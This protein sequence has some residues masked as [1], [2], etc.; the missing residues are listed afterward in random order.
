MRGEEFDRLVDAHREHFADV[1]AA[2]RD[3]Q[4]LGI[5]ALAA[6]GVAQHLDV[7]QEAHL[8]RLHALPFAAFAAAARRVERK[9]TR[10]CSRARA[11]RSRPQ[12]PCG[13]R[14][15]SRRTWPGT[16]AA[17]C[18]SA[19]GRPRARGR[20]TP[21][22]SMPSQPT[23]GGG[24]PAAR[25]R[26]ARAQVRVQH[27]ARERRLAR[28]R[29]TG[30]DR[31][32]AERH[33]R[34]DLAQVVQRGALDLERTAPARPTGRRRAERMA[35]RVARGTARSATAATRSGRRCAGADDV[36]AARAGAGTEVDQVIGAPDRVLVVLDDEQR[37]ALARRAVRARRAARRCRADA[38]RS[39][40]RRA[41]SR[42]R[43]G[44]SRVARRGGCAAPRRRTAS[45]RRGRARYNPGRRRAGRPGASGSPRCR[46]RAI[47]ASRPCSLQTSRKTR[48][49]RRPAA[50]AS[51]AIDW[52]AKR[53]VERDRD[54]AA[55][56]RRPGRRVA[57]PSNHSFHQISSPDCSASKPLMRTPVPKHAS[58]QPCFELY[59]NSRGS[60]SAKLR[61]HDGAGATR[62]ENAHLAAVDDVR[63]ALA[64][65]ERALQRVTQLPLVLRRDLDARRRAARSCA[66]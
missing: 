55:A 16:N 6:A 17:S 22:P 13:S 61:P 54:S 42:R 59:E 39:S 36:A 23:Q 15:R 51:S 60:G 65:V 32:P 35:Q 46:S 28:T 41:R 10:R 29:H 48:A 66:P 20:A 62:R 5:E 21:Q 57:S 14:P 4:R 24:L 11:H 47:S 56:R 58:H 2:I 26:Q 8:D 40:A 45:A 38:G 64:E 7:R 3:R 44:S 18:R 25:L 50:P 1:A 53:D 19:S 33:A 34:V 9:A 27:V 49:R 30:D 37:V 31:E 52:L 43:A 63:D 12:T